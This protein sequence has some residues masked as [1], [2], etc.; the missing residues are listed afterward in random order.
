MLTTGVHQDHVEHGQQQNFTSAVQQV[1]EN[2]SFCN[3]V[4]VPL[5]VSVEIPPSR[6][7][8]TFFCF[9]SAHCL[10]CLDMFAIVKSVCVCV[11]VV[12]GWG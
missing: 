9:V 4:S 11:C 1:C 3:C 7:T 12:E 5:S 10:V 6:H 8:V 2:G